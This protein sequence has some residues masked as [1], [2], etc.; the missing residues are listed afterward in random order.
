MTALN[1]RLGVAIGTVLML[2]AL[3]AVGAAIAP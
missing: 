3:A 1:R 2:V